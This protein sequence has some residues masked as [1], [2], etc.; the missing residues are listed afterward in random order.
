MISG[1][2]DKNI[3]N[4]Y[5][6]QYLLTKT[7]N[8]LKMCSGGSDNCTTSTV[9]DRAKKQTRKIKINH[10]YIYKCTMIYKNYKNF[11]DEMR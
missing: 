9:E 2:I 7:S 11:L 3:F 5:Y 6:L 1:K 10:T 8:E 4:H